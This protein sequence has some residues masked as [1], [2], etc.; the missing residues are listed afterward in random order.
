MSLI[1]I[2]TDIKN[3][4]YTISHARFPD[5]TLHLNEAD[6]RELLWFLQTMEL[7]LEE[8]I[9]PMKPAERGL[10][11]MAGGQ[12]YYAGNV[13]PLFPRSFNYKQGD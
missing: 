8:E 4:R 3:A 2:L 9:Q 10:E 5:G 7:R 13:V 1:S 12:K 11:A 6:A